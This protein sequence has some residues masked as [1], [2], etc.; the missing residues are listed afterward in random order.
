MTRFARQGR[1]EMVAGLAQ[2]GRAVV[3]RGAI[4]SD[5]GVTKLRRKNEACRVR[6]AHLARRDRRNMGGRFSDRN[7]AVV[8]GCAGCGGWNVRVINAANITPR[9][10]E[11]ARLAFLI[12]RHMVLRLARHRLA[13]VTVET[14]FR[15]GHDAAS[16]VAGRAG[17]RLV[18]SRERI[19]S[20]RVI[21]WRAG[22]LGAG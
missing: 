7:R 18:T 1:R 20:H 19:A 14:K 5:P 6:M 15:R 16:N 9:G 2:G 22:R 10:R 4:V 21:E 12:R 3:T 11:M 13:I 8:A 17:D